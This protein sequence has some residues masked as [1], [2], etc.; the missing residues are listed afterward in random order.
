M[1]LQAKTKG[2]L[3]APGEKSRTQRLRERRLKKAFQKRKAARSLKAL[4]KQQ[5]EA[6][7]VKAKLV[8]ARNTTLAKESKGKRKEKKWAEKSLSSSK[9]F[10]ERLQ[11][12]VTSAVNPAKKKPRPEK[13]RVAASGFKL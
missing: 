13:A 12:Q 9:K 6:K 3:V 7:E 5:Q 10:F 4:P 2:E 1:L 8:K 11:D